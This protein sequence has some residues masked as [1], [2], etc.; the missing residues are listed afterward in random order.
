MGLFGRAPPAPHPPRSSR[1]TWTHRGGDMDTAPPPSI[2]FPP[3]P[4]ASSIITLSSFSS[5]TSFFLLCISYT[6]GRGSQ[7]GGSCTAA[8]S[9]GV[10]GAHGRS[11]QR[12]WAGT[13]DGSALAQQRRSRVLWGR[14]CAAVEASVATV[15]ARLAAVGRCSLPAVL[16]VLASRGGGLP[17]AV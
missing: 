1:F 17:L 11:S 9:C 3:G 15:G 16:A 4:H 8:G 7:R 6:G 2:S 12:S 13:R 10:A 14:A 5:H